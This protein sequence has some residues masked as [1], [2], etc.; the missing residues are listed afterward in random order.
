MYLDTLARISRYIN[1]FAITSPESV[2]VVI[3]SLRHRR[4]ALSEGDMIRIGR[5]AMIV[6]KTGADK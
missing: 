4:Y 2:W 6:R 1:G 5:I 3:K